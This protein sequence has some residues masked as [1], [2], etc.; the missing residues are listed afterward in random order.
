MNVLT[1]TTWVAIYGWGPETE[2]P[3]L[4]VYATTSNEAEALELA[5]TA[6][7]KWGR[8]N[9]CACTNQE[10]QRWTVLRVPLGQLSP[11]ADKTSVSL[12]IGKRR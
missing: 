10:P 11:Q 6:A 8:E 3:A 7:E 1:M 5:D 2:A 4:V 12:H 9:V